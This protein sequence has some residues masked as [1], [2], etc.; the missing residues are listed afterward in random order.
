MGEGYKKQHT[1]F[2]GYYCTICR[3]VW[4]DLHLGMELKHRGFPSFGLERKYCAECKELSNI[5][6][7]VLTD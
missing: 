4:E 5:E 1:R 7:P 2:S 3:L 6:E